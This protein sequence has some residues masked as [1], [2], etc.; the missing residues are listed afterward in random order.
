MFEKFA[1]HGLYIINPIALPLYMQANLLALPQI[2]EIEQ[3]NS[4][5]YLMDINFL[6][7]IAMILEEEI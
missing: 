6:L 5:Q 1:V 3:L 2:Q 4:L 7:M